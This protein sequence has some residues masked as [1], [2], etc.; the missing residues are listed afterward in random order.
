MKAI[1][2]LMGSICDE[3]KLSYNETYIEN[4]YLE[5]QNMKFSNKEGGRS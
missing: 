3:K 5:Y 2:E 1:I 4:K